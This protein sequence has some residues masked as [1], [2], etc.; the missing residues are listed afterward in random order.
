MLKY[1]IFLLFISCS[2]TSRV[3]FDKEKQV[4]LELEQKQREYHFKK[5]AKA[6]TELSSDD[7]LIVDNGAVTTPKRKDQLKMFTNYFDAVEL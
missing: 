1:F 3:N 6:I 5:N 2:L 7:F 4:L